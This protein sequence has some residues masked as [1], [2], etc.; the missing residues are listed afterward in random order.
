MQLSKVS[1]SLVLGIEYLFLL[2]KNQL[3]QTFIID[4]ECELLGGKKNHVIHRVMQIC[5]KHLLLL[6]SLSPIEKLF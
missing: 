4:N 6:L 2:L 5:F 1:T 3:W